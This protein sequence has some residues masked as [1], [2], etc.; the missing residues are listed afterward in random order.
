MKPSLSKIDHCKIDNI[1]A[2]LEN[3]IDDYLEDG[4]EGVV[5]HTSSII[6]ATNHAAAEMF[7]YTPDELIYINAWLFFHPSGMGAILHHLLSKS[8]EPYS[9]DALHKDGSHFVV[10]LK[11]KDFEIAGEPVRSVQL[12]K[13]G[14]K[15]VGVVET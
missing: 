15:I 14:N 5:L 1:L 2:A 7:G 13:K 6:I 10:E 4:Y 9:A 8:E 12:N 11:G 3:D